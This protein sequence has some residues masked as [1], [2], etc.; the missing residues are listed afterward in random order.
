MSN[1]DLGS[2]VARLLAWTMEW[3]QGRGE[4]GGLY[5]HSCWGATGILRRRYQGVT[6]SNYYRLIPA[7]LDLYRKTGAEDFLHEVLSM[8]DLLERLQMSDGCFDHSAYEGEPGRGTVICNAVADLGLLYMAEHAED[9]RLAERVLRIVRR[10]LD[11]FGS[12]WWKR[13]NAWRKVVDHPA[14]CAVTNQDLCVA[15]AMCKYGEISGDTSYFEACGRPAVLWILENM[16]LSDLGMFLRGDAPDFLERVVYCGIIDLSLLELNLHLKDGG[17]TDAVVRNLDVILEHTWRDER[18]CLRLPGA[19]DLAGEVE[20]RPSDVLGYSNFIRAI[21]VLEKSYGIEKYRRTKE[22]LL[23]TVT[24]YQSGFGG[25]RSEARRGDVIDLVP[26][27][28]NFGVLSLLA[29]LWDGP[30]V[31]EVE[32]PDLSIAI[33]GR[34]LWAED[35]RSWLIRDGDL[36]Y[37]GVKALR[38]GIYREKRVEGL[39][40]VSVGKDRVRIVLDRGFEG[41]RIE[42]ELVGDVP[43]SVSVEGIEGEVQLDIR[44]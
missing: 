5:L 8:V 18:G 41:S 11:W 9:E 15:C 20:E 7:F 27:S 43:R 29:S 36:V 19:F 16:Y 12:Y 40:E 26:L 25:I 24:S 31:P 1:D 35:G 14:W 34:C 22:E 30:E 23:R 37:S 42:V 13:G 28:G 10:N 4:F 44:Y 38:D 3:R 33:S 6:V 21:D 2:T 39:R 32:R 17:I